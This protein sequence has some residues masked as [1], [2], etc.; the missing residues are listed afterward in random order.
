MC[1]QIKKILTQKFENKRIV[2]WYDKNREHTR[3]Y[4][5]IELDGVKKLEISENEFALK[6][7]ILKEEPNQKFL[8]YKPAPKPDDEDNWLLDVLLANDEFQTESWALNLNELGLGTEFRS[9]TEDHPFF[10]NNRERK[11]KLKTML[12]KTD[13]ISEI[14]K[15][16]LAVI[17]G[18]EN[19]LNSIVMSLLHEYAAGKR[20]MEDFIRK[21]KLDGFLFDQ[22]FAA[23]GYQTD[24]PSIKD[25]IIKVFKW[26]FEVELNKN[27]NER[28]LNNDA[29]IFLNQ[30]KNDN[31]YT[32]DFEKISAEV[33]EMLDI[34][35]IVYNESCKNLADTDYFEVIDR[36]I[37]QTLIG[38]LT[39]STASLKEIFDMVTRRRTMKWYKKFENLYQT[40]WFAALFKQELEKNTQF[41][42]YSVRD[43][44]EG[45]VEKWY[46]IDQYYRKFLYHQKSSGQVSGFEKLLE[47]IENLYANKYLLNLNDS[48]QQQLNNQTIWDFGCERQRDFY[49]HYVAGSKTK[50]AVIVSDALRYEIGEELATRIRQ[51]DRFEAVV[52]KAITGLPSYTQLGMASLLPNETLEITE[53][54]ASVLTDGLPS[55]GLENRTKILQQKNSRIT[56]LK[57]QDVLNSNSEVL[58]ETVKNNDVIYIFHNRI[59][60]V[61][62]NLS[63]EEQAFE[64]SETAIED[65]LKLIKKAVNAN[66]TKVLVT[67]DHGFIYQNKE[68]DEDGYLGVEAT[69]E[70]IIKKDRRFVIGRGLQTDSSFM[71]FDAKSLG[72]EG[73]LEF[74]FPKSIN[75][76]RLQ[77]AAVRFV[78]G[79]ASLQEIIVPVVVINK[80][81]QS[82]I[83][84]VEVDV[85]SSN[86]IISSNQLV[87]TLYQKEPISDK[88][89]PLTLNVGLY[90]KTG[91]LLSETREIIFDKTSTETRDRE[92]QITLSL[93]R[94]IDRENNQTVYLKLSEP[95]ENTTCNK[96]YKSAEYTVRK[97]FERDF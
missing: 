38:K 97:I 15:K 9:I 54:D 68:P 92:Q 57:E 60:E 10:F 21:S 48:W 89:R 7:H 5:E 90:N 12:G 45:Y 61:G 51:E 63:S 64:A 32:A 14:K 55:S 50:L 87:V 66:I 77:G 28:N 39:D 46:K 33:S 20:E 6:Y 23:Y 29:K 4:A 27:A 59:D 42:V 41:E 36:F 80:K 58:R 67:A 18:A 79:G 78:H 17:T 3:E 76:L 8:L 1:E 75:R 30:W 37:V 24:K 83:G 94:N 81:R 40:I 19:D 11:Q 2:F 73:N 85:Y 13:S 62:H 47:N 56:A 22:M 52:N 65:L 31:R 35:N 93:N 25:F 34:E 86:R 91:E 88:V 70:Q 96:P 16:M 74:L 84:K 69:G 95:Q 49:K 82:D 44:I 43:G 53:K 26:C 71:K 72:L